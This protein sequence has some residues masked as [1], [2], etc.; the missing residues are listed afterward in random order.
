M[1]AVLNSRFSPPQGWHALLAHWETS[2]CIGPEQR[3]DLMTALR[4]QLDLDP[5]VLHSPE[6]SD[7][8]ARIQWLSLAIDDLAL[9]IVIGERRIARNEADL[10][11]AIDIA[12][13]LWRHGHHGDAF[14]LCRRLLLLN[15][16]AERALSVLQD[17]LAWDRI[18]WPLPMPAAAWCDGT[19]TLEPLG[20]HHIDDFAHAYI[21]PTIAERCCLPHF[22]SNREWDDWLDRSN[23]FNDQ[24]TFGVWHA[25]WGFIGSVSMVMV[26]DIGFFYYWIARAFQ[27]Q[28]FGPQA[29]ALLFDLAEQAWG[30]RCCY[31]KVF[32]DNTASIRALSKLGFTPTGIAIRS[33][34][35]DEWLYRWSPAPDRP[36]PAELSAEAHRLFERMGSTTRVLS[37]IVPSRPTT[38]TA[39]YVARPGDDPNAIR[40]KDQP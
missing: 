5:G 13:A 25:D 16:H 23:G 36:T 33:D 14:A 8:R 17:I 27:G 10:N 39:T 7:L 9:A 20:H 11:D 38:H 29:A 4:Q 30:M 24:M 19:L 21:D 26:G 15:P 31:A 1:S 32:T 28:G 40:R 6:A 37:L 12:I 3:I 18:V 2:S 22:D 34:Q 35:R